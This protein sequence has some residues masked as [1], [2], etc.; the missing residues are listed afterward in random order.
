MANVKPPEFVE[1]LS[2]YEKAEGTLRVART[3]THGLEMPADDLGRL[4][5]EIAH[6]KALRSS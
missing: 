1:S 3:V 6:V 4:L 5:V 2:H